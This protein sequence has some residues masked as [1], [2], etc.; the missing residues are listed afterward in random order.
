MSCR[1][2]FI[3]ISYATKTMWPDSM[4]LYSYYGSIAPTPGFPLC[5]RRLRHMLRARVHTMVG[6]HDVS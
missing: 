5:W 6:V 2:S 1:M 4:I 3:L